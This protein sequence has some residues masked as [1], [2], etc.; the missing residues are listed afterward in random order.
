MST[1][2]ERHAPLTSACDTVMQY[3]NSN[4]EHVCR[5]DHIDGEVHSC[6]C[7]LVWRDTS[8]ADEVEQ[9]LAERDALK[10]AIE[11]AAEAI[12]AAHRI[13]A[14][15]SHDWSQ[16]PSDAWLYALLVGWDC[17][18]PEH[19]N[20]EHDPIDCSGPNHLE[21]FAERFGWTEG[22]VAKIRAQR[23]AL[24]ALDTP[25]APESPREDG[26]DDEPYIV[27]ESATVTG[28]KRLGKPRLLNPNPSWPTRKPGECTTAIYED[29]ES[30]ESEE[31]TD[32]R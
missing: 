5:L 20:G 27:D 22:G 24:A 10:A 13:M 29:P 6:T 3:P 7:G 30:P 16:H 11:G 17:E 9:L 21:D 26:V 4:I 31:T 1:E 12:Q 19:A 25:S 28:G 15:S 8:R 32:G 18:L 23:R 14:T 2:T